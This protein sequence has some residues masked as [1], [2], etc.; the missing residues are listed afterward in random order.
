M[1]KLALALLLTATPVL[2]A[3]PPY[4]FKRGEISYMRT[5]SNTD[6]RSVVAVAKRWPGDFIWTRRDGRE[7]LIRDAAVL[8]EARRAYARLDAMNVE[9]HAF[10]KRMRPVERRHD[11]LE[12]KTEAIEEQLEEKNPSRSERR[13]LE[14]RMRELEREMRVLE[15]DLRVLEDEEERLD[16]RQEALEKVAE[17][18]L[19]EIIR[20]ALRRGGA[21]R[22]D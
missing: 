20:R 14:A 15:K 1:R 17:E 9:I 22:V 7:Y 8:A 2:A 11:F 19:E 6:I 5:N 4:V 18:E 13:E 21:E 12:D 16:D 3:D 10:E